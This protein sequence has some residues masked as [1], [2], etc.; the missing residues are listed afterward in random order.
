M[1]DAQRRVTNEIAEHGGRVIRTI[2][3]WW[4]V[5]TNEACLGGVWLPDHRRGYLNTVVCNALQRHGYLVATDLPTSRY[6]HGDVVYELV[7]EHATV[8]PALPEITHD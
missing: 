1:T 8:Q 4:S 2:H 6:G 5:A 3:G 7:G